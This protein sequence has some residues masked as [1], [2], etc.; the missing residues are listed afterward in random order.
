MP[1]CLTGLVA[2]HSGL[3]HFTHPHSTDEF[4]D[5]Q[6][7]ENETKII[8]FANY[9]RMVFQ[10]PIPNADQS[11]LES[12]AKALG[13]CRP[14]PRFFIYEIDFIISSSFLIHNSAGHLARAGGT[15]TS[16]FV[17]FEVKRALEWL[18]GT[19]R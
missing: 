1:G 9:L 15:L 8:R 3:H 12:A 7:E 2:K 19:W 16:D 13:T 18:Q 5:L 6:Y 14:V 11:I 17:E 10:Q 4:I